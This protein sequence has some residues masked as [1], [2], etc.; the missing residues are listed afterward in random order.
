VKKLKIKLPIIKRYYTKN[1]PLVMLDSAGV[2]HYWDSE[3]NYDGY[4][5]KT[6][7]SCGDNMIYKYGCHICSSCGYAID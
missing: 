4:S 3:Y 5:E 1:Y 6:C 2:T 7:P